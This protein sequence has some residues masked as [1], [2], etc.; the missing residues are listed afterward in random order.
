MATEKVINI[1][2]NKSI[3]D[4]KIN[5]LTDT[6]QEQKD[7]T[8]ELQKELIRLQNEYKKTGNAAFSPKRAQLAKDIAH[9]KEAIK[10]QTVSLRDLNNQKRKAV[11]GVAEY[12]GVLK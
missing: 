1:V 2:V 11:K 12:S 5:E 8:I 3:A 7:I 9:V 4:K 10:D 6:I